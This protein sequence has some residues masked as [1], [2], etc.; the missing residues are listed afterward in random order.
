MDEPAEAPLQEETPTAALEEAGTG[1]EAPAEAAAAAAPVNIESLLTSE[2]KENL[3]KLDT[4]IQDLVINIY[5]RIIIDPD[6]TIGV[7]NGDISSFDSAEKIQKLFVA[8]NDTAIEAAKAV[9][10][11]IIDESSKGFRLKINPDRTLNAKANVSRVGETITIRLTIHHDFKSQIDGV[12]G[13]IC[14]ILTDKNNDE[15]KKKN[16]KQLDVLLDKATDELMTL[17]AQT[18]EVKDGNAFT[19]A[20]NLFNN[21]LNEIINPSVQEGGSR[22]TRVVEMKGGA[23]VGSLNE[24]YNA[25]DLIKDDHPPSDIVGSPAQNM[26]QYSPASFSAGSALS[27]DL[28]QGIAQPS[29]ELLNPVSAQQ[30]AGAKK[31]VIK[32]K[33]RSDSPKKSKK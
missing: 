19:D 5:S 33:K 16:I 21:K 13:Q 8:G 9:A 25:R 4:D 29:E 15:E 26:V 22:K 27:Q 12:C 24:I 2:E 28:A 31:K 6:I 20:F 1:T 10:S 14:T 7:Q 3:N 30:V 17:L 23:N 11:Q 32:K 18:T